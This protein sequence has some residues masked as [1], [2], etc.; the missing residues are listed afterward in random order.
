[1]KFKSIGAMWVAGLLLCLPAAQADTLAVAVAAN[2]QYA[3]E[4]I[5]TAFEQESGHKLVASYNSSGKFATQIMQGAPLDVFLSAD[6][7]YPEQLYR[8]GFASQPPQ[9]Y[10]YGALVL[11]TRK[12]YDLGQW[13]KLLAGGTVGRIALANPKTAP[14][15]REAMRVLEY[16]RLD[17][18]L[19]G[20]LVL[21]ESIAQT[22]QYIHSGAVDIGFTAKS[23]V[24]APA[25][26]G[27]G[28]WIDVPRES[29]QPI[30]QAALLLKH[31]E[32]TQAQAAQR[33]YAFL[34]G[35]KARA[36]FQRYGYLLP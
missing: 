21:A 9:V 20:K 28:K 3:F 34:G 22:G 1:M 24:L 8:A 35:A 7:D 5:K 30:A 36:I 14:Y 26:Q 31:G 10:A 33:F 11:W 15:G 17:G 6:R 23:L 18:V 4:E 13:Q 25:M 12:D 27:Q 32:Q 29:Y 16:Y 19:Q 2:L